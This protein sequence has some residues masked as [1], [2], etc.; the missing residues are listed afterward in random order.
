MITFRVRGLLLFFFIILYEALSD[1]IAGDNSIGLWH[2][3]TAVFVMVCIALLLSLWLYLGY[4][5]QK[6]FI[7]W[8]YL[9]AYAVLTPVLGELMRYFI[10][11]KDWYKEISG[12]W[13]FWTLALVL[14]ALTVGYELL[15]WFKHR[16]KQGEEVE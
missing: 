15:E 8:W 14:F 7:H 2:R 9:P 4:N 11:S 16:N 3:V 6:N 13:V 1:N 5:R 10:L 12:S